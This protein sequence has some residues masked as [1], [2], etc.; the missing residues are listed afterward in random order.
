[1]TASSI[2]LTKVSLPFFG[3]GAAVRRP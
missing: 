3:S 2:V 1:L